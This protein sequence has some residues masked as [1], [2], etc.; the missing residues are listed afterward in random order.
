MVARGTFGD[1]VWKLTGAGD[2]VQRR[3]GGEWLRDPSGLGPG[4]NAVMMIVARPLVF[5]G[6]AIAPSASRPTSGC[7]SGSCSLVGLAVPFFSTPVD[8]APPAETASEPEKRRSRVRLRGHRD[9]GGHAARNGDLRPARRPVARGGGS[10]SAPACSPSSGMR[11][12]SPS[13]LGAKRSPRGRGG[14]AVRKTTQP[15]GSPAPTTSRT[16]KAWYSSTSSIRR[17]LVASRCWRSPLMRCQGSSRARS[18]HPRTRRSCRRVL[19]AVADA[20]LGERHVAVVGE[21][22][23]RSRRGAPAPAS[24]A[25]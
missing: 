23:E 15:S 7:S 25:A 8:D 21:Q 19:L 13:P 17:M 9:G 10:W 18:A 16:T 6:L 4:R 3:H 12:P 22:P 24:R 2:H 11:S 14:D 5:G 20:V 1:E